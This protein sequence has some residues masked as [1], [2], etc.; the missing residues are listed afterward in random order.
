M[1]VRFFIL[2]T[3]YRSTVDFSNEALKAA[4]KGL[5]RLMAAHSAITNLIYDE[6]MHDF[7]QEEDNN[8]VQLCDACTVN[9][10]D[11]FNTAMSLASLFELT[12]KIFSWQ[13]GQLKISTIKRETCVIQ[14]PY[15]ESSGR[16]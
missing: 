2:Q 6:N 9:M 7:D 13:N 12:S 1:T 16:I 3:H 4:E 10:N 8:L 15:L 11:D 14:T 5:Q